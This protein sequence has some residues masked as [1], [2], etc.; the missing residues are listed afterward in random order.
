MSAQA[1]TPPETEQAPLD[2]LR[3]GLRYVGVQNVSLLVAIGILVVVVGSQNDRFFRTGNLL[4]IG[5]AVAI[6][7][8][9]ALVET[10]VI[11]AGG[12]DISV[13]SVT[14][15]GSVV[16]AVGL[17]HFGNSAI[18]IGLALLAGL[19]AGLINGLIITIGRVN[20]VITT[21]ATLSAFQGVALLIVNGSPISTAGNEVFHFLGDGTVAGLPAPLLVFALAALATHVLLRYTDIGRNIYAMGGNK[22]AARLAG[23]DLN[24]YVLAVY[25]L[26]GMV[27]GLAGVLLTARTGSGQP[28]SGSQGTELLAVTGAVL[29]G[30]AL[31]GGKG[32]IVGTILAVILLGILDNG[33]VLLNVPDFYQRIAKGALLVVAVV[34]QQRRRRGDRATGFP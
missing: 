15:V 31:T 5:S 4:Q 24:R 10:I 14:G 11:V 16:S 3:R 8:L 18:A 27:A 25:M 32:T 23:I 22:T 19:G 21:L 20:P 12:L 30:C 26:A 1:T 6:V 28:L 29:G 2:R 34:I 17:E 33:F 7:G 9:L 13:G